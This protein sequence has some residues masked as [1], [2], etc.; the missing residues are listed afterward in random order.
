MWGGGGGCSPEK[1]ITQRKRF[2]SGRTSVFDEDHLGCLN[3][4]EMMD[5]AKQVNALIQEDRQLTVTDIANKFDIT[6][7]PAYSIIQEDLGYHKI[8]ARWVP[9]QPKDKH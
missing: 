5:D 3:T 4:S 1:S 2:Q 7:G 8:C 6:C 9:R